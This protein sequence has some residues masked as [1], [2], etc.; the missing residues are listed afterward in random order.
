MKKAIKHLFL[1]LLFVGGFMVM[2]S[3]AP[4]TAGTTVSGGG[5]GCWPP[6]CVPIDGGV[7]FLLAAGLAFGGKK[8]FDLRG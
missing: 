5:A 6:P 3:Y 2:D 1:T 4:P 8:L 7:G